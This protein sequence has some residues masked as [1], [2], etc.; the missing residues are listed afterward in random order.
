MRQ[1]SSTT[2]PLYYSELP[3][4]TSSLY[5]AALLHIL[6]LAIL[7]SLLPVEGVQGRGSLP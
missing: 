3:H 7:P 1:S 6:L 2:G 5:P 4:V